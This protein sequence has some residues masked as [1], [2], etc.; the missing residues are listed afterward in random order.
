MARI[1]GKKALYEVINKSRTQPRYNKTVEPLR[2]EKSST[3]EPVI[4]KVEPVA[5]VKIPQ[6]RKKPNIIQLNAGRIEVSIPYQYAIAIL[7][8]LVV[9]LLVVFRLGQFTQRAA[10]SSARAQSNNRASIAEGIAAKTTRAAGLNEN[11]FPSSETIKPAESKPVESKGDHVIVI[12]QYQN[13][14]DLVPVQQYFAE[15][16]IE[17]EIVQ[18]TGWYFLVTKNRYDNPMT[19]GTDGYKIRQQIINLGPKYKA[20]KGYETFAPNFFKDAYGKKVK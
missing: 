11:L 15:A 16:G 18:Q 2:Q 20:Q 12:V 7:L 14:P 3:P 10:K 13:R 4:P 8:C 19:P 5:T 9:L 1:R 6:W 17:T